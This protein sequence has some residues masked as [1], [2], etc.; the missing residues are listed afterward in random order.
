MQ[1]F[2]EGCASPNLNYQSYT[3]SNTIIHCL[4]YLQNNDPPTSGQPPYIMQT[5]VDRFRNATVA[6]MGKVE[7]I[8]YN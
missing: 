3:Y 1:I 7:D 2:L 4:T 8:H 5:L 6:H